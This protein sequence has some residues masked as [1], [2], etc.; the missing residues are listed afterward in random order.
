MAS[1]AEKIAAF[2]PNAVALKN[3]G[4]FGLPFNIE[5]SEVVVLPI[6]W[7]ATTSYLEGTANA[8]E[9]ILE[10]SKQI[11]L[12]YSKKK[13]SWK[14]G[15]ALRKIPLEWQELNTHYRKKARQAIAL[16]E[17]GIAIENE[18]LI[19]LLT[20]VNAQCQELNEYVYNRSIELLEQ[21]KTVGVLGGDHSTPLG[22][23][24][25]L[26]KKYSSFGILQI[27][28]HADLRPAYEGFTFS[29]ASIMHNALKIEAVSKL[30][31]VG[32]RDVCEQEISRISNSNNR[33]VAFFDEALKAKAFNAITWDSCC[34]DI[35][36]ELPNLV[37][38]S[39]DIDGLSP[40]LCRNTGT[41]V[42]GGLSFEQAIY[43]LKK[44]VDSGRKII[45]FDLCEVGNSNYDANVGARMLYHLCNLAARF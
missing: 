45:G 34:N 4:L 3:A 2:N 19:A 40:D 21:E 11:D 1:K 30:V 5:E 41:P 43:L 25:A 26:S 9:A 24:K 12:C 18:E 8:P 37:Y 22:L 27:D 10:A 15:I 17:D 6:P 32:L 16:L 36:K 44:V 31:S 38:V 35:V 42:P 39:F 28:A 23:I 7:D 14:R 33:I 29:H 13:D 20:E